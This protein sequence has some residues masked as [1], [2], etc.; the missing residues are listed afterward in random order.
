VLFLQ[1]VIH[2]SVGGS[3]FVFVAWRA[4]RAYRFYRHSRP[5]KSSHAGSHPFD[6]VPGRASCIRGSA[7]STKLTDAVSLPVW[8]ARMIE[9]QAKPSILQTEKSD[10]ISERRDSFCRLNI[11]HNTMKCYI[12]GGAVM[13]AWFGLRRSHMLVPDPRR[14]AGPQRTHEMRLI[15]QPTSW[16]AFRLWGQFGETRRK[17][18]TPAPPEALRGC[19]RCRPVRSDDIVGAR[20]ARGQDRRRLAPSRQPARAGL[21]SPGPRFSRPDDAGLKPRAARQ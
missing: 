11:N 7:P 6:A 10:V 4:A 20:H 3:A 19:P 1:I 8:P 16:S 18:R 15:E 9:P 21:V 14:V 2:F 13:S 17:D 12:M 5:T